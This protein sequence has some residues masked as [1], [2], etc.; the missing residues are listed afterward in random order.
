MDIKRRDEIQATIRDNG[1]ILLKELEKIYPDVSGMTLRRDLD[2]LEKKGFVIRVRGGA[3]SM[4]GISGTL[5]DQF[6]LRMAEHND[7]KIAVARKA[8]GLLE[9]DRAIFIDSG[10]TMMCLARLMPDESF[11]ILTSGPNIGLEIIKKNNPTVTLIGGQL[12]RTNLTT[13]GVNSLDFVKSINIDIAF[14]AASGFSLKSGFT[15]GNYSECELKKLII[16][17]AR[18]VI[19]LMDASKID[20][21]M[22][23]TFAALKDIDMLVSDK[24]L[25][26]QVSKTADKYGVMIY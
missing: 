7:A 8:I 24:T 22:P 21:S 26:E 2:Y 17:R 6:G 16:K 23:F 1:G 20:K 9:K 4:N 12:S 25:P 13:S 3:K 5:E 11:S 10:T 15:I 18:K 14:L 19:L